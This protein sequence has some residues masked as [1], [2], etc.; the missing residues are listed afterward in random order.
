MIDVSAWSGLVLVEE[1]VE[2]S[3]RS[4]ACCCVVTQLRQ[5]ERSVDADMRA[6]PPRVRKELMAVFDSYADAP[7]TLVHGDPGPSNLRVLDGAVGFL[8]WDES[9]V[10]IS[11]HDLSELGASVLDESTGVRAQLLSHAWETANAWTTEPDYAKARL[12][13]L[14]DL[15]E[16]E[17]LQ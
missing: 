3:R 14:R 12:Q 15:S 17:G 16:T 4:A 8:D 5:L 10:D 1:I 6:L 11:W 7:V 9:R 13:K 2:G